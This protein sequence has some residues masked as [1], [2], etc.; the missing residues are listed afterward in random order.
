M[1]NRS[2]ILA[3]MMLWSAVALSSMTVCRAQENGPVVDLGKATLAGDEVIA[4]PSG[5]GNIQLVDNYFDDDASRRLFDQMDYQRACQAYIWSTPLVS[6]TTW[7]DAEAKAYGVTSETDFVVLKSL[8]EKRGIVTANLTTPYIFNF[9]SLADGPLQI[10]YPAGQT[11]GG[12]LDFWQ[13]PVFDLGLT[14]PDKG[15]GATYVVVGPE[16]DPAK[17]KKDGVNV[18][19]NATNNIFIG[20]RILEKTPGYFDRFAS[21]YRIGRDG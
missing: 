9:I 16:G 21:Q 12:V 2:Q 20:L 8:K 13:R 11:A 10:D 4:T 7:R 1:T 5:I 15:K 3:T 19:Q 17:Y 6:M 18:F 14:G